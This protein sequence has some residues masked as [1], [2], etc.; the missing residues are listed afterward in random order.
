MLNLITKAYLFGQDVSDFKKIFKEQGLSGR[1]KMWRDQGEL[2]KLYNLVAHV[3]ASRKQSDLFTALQETKNI[4]IIA[5]K[6]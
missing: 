3:I 6:R 4:S 2:R 1:Q 5:R